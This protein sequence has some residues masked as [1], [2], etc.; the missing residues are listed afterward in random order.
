M[1]RRKG[2]LQ[3]TRR[4][5][6]LWLVWIL[7]ATLA[8]FL[9]VFF[10]GLSMSYLGPMTSLG[11]LIGLLVAWLAALQL[12]KRGDRAKKLNNQVAI[13]IQSNDY[14][15]ALELCE[16]SPAVVAGSTELRYNQA[17]IR[18]VLGRRQE[19]LAELERLRQ[20]EPRFEMTSLLLCS[21]YADEG[22]WQRGLELA[23]QLSRNLPDEPSGPQMESWLLRKLGRLDE[24]EARAQAALAMDPEAG[25]GCMTLAAV[26]LDRGDL[27]EARERLTR[28]ERLVP[29]TV[30]VALLKAELALATN[31]PEVEAAVEQAVRSSR[32][33]P[34]AFAEKEI[35]G[36]VRRMEERRQP[37]RSSAIQ[38]G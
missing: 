32:N 11:V 6:R 9:V 1:N 25:A 23:T 36:L 2:R 5:W 26:A 16:A 29:G 13:A 24:A 21:I 3:R 7:S 8:G 19:A 12:L 38:P 20:D 35:A 10:T 18:A 28:A 22:E 27:A 4:P 17:L 14:P 37:E 34:L 31:D 15:K 33:N 30:G